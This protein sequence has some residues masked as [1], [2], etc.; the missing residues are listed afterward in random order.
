MTM[1]VRWFG[2]MAT[3]AAVAGLGAAE[4]QAQEAEPLPTGLIVGSLEAAIQQPVDGIENLSLEV[5]LSEKTLYVKSGD[6]VVRTYPV[7]VGRAGQRT[8]TGTFT[9]RRMEWNP[10]WVPPNSPWARGM[11]RKGPGDPENPMG[12]VKMLFREPYYFIHGTGAVSSLGRDASAG[13]VRMRDI[14]AVE[15]ARL[16]MEN[17]GASRADSWYQETIA[18]SGTTRTVTLRNPVRVRVRA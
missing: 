1:L 9:I 17:G 4:A 14:D 13:C 11:T 15:L 16:V 8:P 5:S 12:R 6:R 2:T 3:V 7:S 10:S 18:R